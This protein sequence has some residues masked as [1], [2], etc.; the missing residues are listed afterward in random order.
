VALGRAYSFTLKWLEELPR[1][2]TATDLAAAAITALR[3]GDKAEMQAV[4]ETINADVAQNH[5]CNIVAALETL[6]V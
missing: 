6:R 2:A 3:A 4:V 5:A 1:T